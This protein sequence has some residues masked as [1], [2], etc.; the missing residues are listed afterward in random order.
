LH[1]LLIFV[2]DAGVFKADILHDAEDV[3]VEMS[4]HFLELPE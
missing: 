1:K 2:N 4:E 3:D